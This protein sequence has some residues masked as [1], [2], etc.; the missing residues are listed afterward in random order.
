ML[1][2]F[3]WFLRAR[4]SNLCWLEMARW[5]LPLLLLSADINISTAATISTPTSSQDDT[6]MLDVSVY[7]GTFSGQTID[8]GEKDHSQV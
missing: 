2:L 3:T 5:I 7:N 8:C 4:F 6:V 1:T